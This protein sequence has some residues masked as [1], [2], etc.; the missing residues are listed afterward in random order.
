[1]TSTIV[2]TATE[3]LKPPEALPDWFGGTLE[4]IHGLPETCDKDL[5]AVINVAE[6]PGDDELTRQTQRNLRIRTAADMI[7]TETVEAKSK[8]IR[9]I[10]E[11]LL[12]AAEGDQDGEYMAKANIRTDAMERLFKAGNILTV[13]LSADAAGNIYQHGQRM[14]DIHRNAYLMASGHPAIM[15]RTMAEANNGARIKDAYERGLLKDYA[16][17]VLSICPEEISDE[18]LDELNFFSLTKSMSVQLTTET[19]QGLKT[20]SAFVAGVTDE[21][22]DRHDRIMV[23]EFGARHGIDYRGKGAAE[24]IDM[25]LLIHRDRLPNGAVDV[26]QALD[27]INGGTFF[28][29]DK[30]VEDY[31]RFKRFCAER[32]TNFEQN[33][34]E[35][36]HDLVAEAGNFASAAVASKRLGKL[37]EARL[38]KRA[39]TE[40]GSIDPRVFG[41]VSAAHIERARE[42][43]ASGQQEQAAEQLIL[44]QK[45]AK[46][47][48]CPSALNPIAML[49]LPDI[50]SYL[51]AGASEAL[52]SLEG[53]QHGSLIFF[54]PK[55][56]CYN[57][58]KYGK[59]VEECQKCGADVTCK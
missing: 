29:Q 43:Y 7:M 44:A 57:R 27:E 46:S 41:S 40:D 49:S 28:G 56:G 31:V 51:L 55:K 1:M 42:M 2:E 26:V 16:F 15:P 52:I 14:D 17:V 8:P 32:E 45:T 11:A 58:R 20:E 47:G 54:C 36:Y 59:L 22:S 12:W 19:G 37:V 33:V 18:E 9:D 53:D 34:E 5:P 38:V 25:P 39:I 23:E 6:L 10:R 13:D 21:H 35:I 48:S 4:D 3:I 30:P 24:I 50:Q